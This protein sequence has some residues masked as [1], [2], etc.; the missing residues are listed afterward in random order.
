MMEGR[1]QQLADEVHKRDEDAIIELIDPEKGILSVRTTLAL[2]SMTQLA[3]GDG[4]GKDAGGLL[5]ED[6]H[7]LFVEPADNVTIAAT[8]Y[9][10]LGMAQA[11]FLSVILGLPLYMWEIPHEALVTLVV[12][13]SVAM[14]LSYGAMYGLQR[15]RPQR[16][17]WFALSAL[18]L[19]AWWLSFLIMMGSASGLS[20][21]LVPFQLFSIQWIQY[22]ALS[23]YLQWLGPGA[24]EASFLHAS[25]AMALGSLVIWGVSIVTFAR[26]ADWV[27]AMLMLLCALGSLIYAAHQMQTAI[28]EKRYAMNRNDLLAAFLNYHVDVPLKL[29]ER[30]LNRSG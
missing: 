11:S 20:R 9:L 4:G 25:L 1:Y 30:L 15:E 18:A 5:L 2:D 28:D 3:S 17:H 23:I 29:K 22:A 6:E 16:E 26:D 8:K 10:F 24:K 27:A 21:S 19:G 7:N 14:L 13:S 12:L